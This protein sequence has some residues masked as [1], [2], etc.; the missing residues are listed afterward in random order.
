MNRI[1]LL[2]CIWLFAALLLPVFLSGAFPSVCSASVIIYYDD[3]EKAEDGIL[4]ANMMLNL[5]G[6]FDSRIDTAGIGN[7]KKD[8]MTA[9]DYVIYIGQKK[10]SLTDHFLEDVLSRRSRVLWIAANFDQLTKFAKDKNGPGFSV[11]G[12]NTG[13]GYELLDYKGKILSR[14]GDCSFFEVETQ[15]TMKI[16]S[17]LRSVKEEGKEFPHFL[18][19]GN[20]FYM[21]ENPLPYQFDDRIFVFADALH[22]FFQ[23]DIP[24][25]RLAMVKFEDLAPGVCDLDRLRALSK[26]LQNK[27]IPF[28]AG[29][30][31]IYKD[32]EGLY[33]PAGKTVRLRDDREFVRV[34]KQMQKQGGTLVMHGVTH[35]HG[36]GISRVDWEFVQGS[37]AL[38]LSYDSKQWVQRRVLEGLM[39][40]RRNGLDPMIWETPHYSASYGDY[41]TI[42]EYFD[43]FYE[44]PLVFPVPQ[45]EEPKFGTPQNP[46]NQIVP[47]YA[48]V[49]SLGAGLLPETLGYIN[50]KDPN[51]TVQAIQDKAKKIKIIRDGVA[52]FYFHHDMVTDE[53]LFGVIDALLLEGYT[54]VGPDYFLSQKHDRAF[55]IRRAFRKVKDWFSLIQMRCQ[56][57][58]YDL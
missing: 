9:Y 18:C 16:Y 43:T 55:K 10:Q 47:Y 50:S 28:S 15:S 1:R 58:D 14:I 36:Q 54:F 38:P 2:P 13:D 27:N 45:N 26:K 25:T 35:Q 51:A 41:R 7:Y 49:C 52:S 31:P 34:L 23:T 46:A 3:A 29:V 56:D 21:A 57:P 30:I 32:P 24:E 19:D 11:K 5:A 4:H 44:K 33:G 22:E 40:F 37:N 6:H 17:T 8:Q 48:H 12:W 39:E 20:L 53:E 42:A